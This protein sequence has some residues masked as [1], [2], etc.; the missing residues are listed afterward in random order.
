MC[1]NPTLIP[2]PNLR[3]RIAKSFKKDTVSQFIPVPCGHCSECRATRSFGIIQRCELEEI[4]GYPYMI[5][6]TYSN[7]MIPEITC[8]D[9]VTVKYA[10]F[11]DVTKMFK[12]LRKSNAIGRP[13]RYLCISER[14][15]K[16]G[17][18][19][20]H[21]LL[22]VQKREGDSVYTPFNLEKVVHDSVLF[23]WRRNTATTISKRGKR[24][25]YSIPNNRQPIYKP[26]CQYV[27][28][29]VHGKLYSN[30]G[31][32]YVQPSTLDG[33]TVGATHYVTKYFLK[34]DKFSDALQS[35][36]K[37]NL[38]S[39]EYEKVWSLVRPR[40]ISSLNFGFGLYSDYN[41]K[42]VSRSQRLKL[43]EDLPTFKHV[44]S[45]IKR[46]LSSYDSPK[47]NYVYNG[48]PI[49][50]SRYFYHVDNLYTPEVYNH[51]KELNNIYGDYVQIEE[52]SRQELLD[53][54]LIKSKRL[55]QAF[56]ITDLT[57]LI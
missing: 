40:Y 13:F 22:Y 24:Q 35:A 53:N 14:G 6:L 33:S 3:S 9:G 27:E 46:S 5:L 25:G 44:Q 54:E 26:L 36:L 19:H 48:R 18:P 42:N 38:P 45:C 32:H 30:F 4:T 23:E 52:R 43:L 39:F 57:D 31:C 29:H 15:G 11:N 12:R 7:D 28:F 50:L 20:F 16:K 56:N 55:N 8:S 17:R 37:I 2:N 21:L 47:Y 10:D 1:T 49:P 41:A 51:F 34:M